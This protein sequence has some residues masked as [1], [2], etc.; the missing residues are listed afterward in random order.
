LRENNTWR[1]SAF[2]GAAGQGAANKRD[3]NT[4]KSTVFGSATPNPINRKKLGGESKGT[5]VLFG[6]D[7]LDYLRSSHNLEIKEA[8]SVKKEVSCPDR[9]EQVNRE[10][11][12][13]TAEIFGTHYE[14][15]KDG[16]LMAQ[17]VDWRNPW[18]KAIQT[19]DAIVRDGL[20][21]RERKHQNLQ[22]SVFGGGYMDQQKPQVNKEIQRIQYGCEQDWKTRAALEHPKNGDVEA[23][24]AYNRK[25]KELLSSNVN[26]APAAYDEN[27]P[28][29][30]G[31]SRGQPD[32]HITDAPIAKPKKQDEVFK[33]GDRNVRE[34]HIEN[35]DPRERASQVLQGNY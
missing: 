17:C 15:R 11:H 4:F 8:A 26:F 32:A 35:Y 14:N 6:Q 12:G 25:Q 3:I 31:E 18:V 28:K 27:M 23:V 2:E 5:E 24:A 30:K 34:P 10:L 1:S 21:H 19:D 33:Q 13:Q 20:D 22:S 9:K 7:R 16:A 29:T